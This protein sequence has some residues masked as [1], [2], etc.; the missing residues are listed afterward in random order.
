MIAVVRRHFRIIM[1]W[2]LAL[3]VELE[4]VLYLCWLPRLTSI[5]V[6]ITYV[7]FNGGKPLVRAGG[8]NQSLLEYP[9]VFTSITR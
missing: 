3:M 4:R 9:P 2:K 1:T 7:N 8:C 5:V 6:E